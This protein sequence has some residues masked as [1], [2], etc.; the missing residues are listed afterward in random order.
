[1]TFKDAILLVRLGKART[2][3]RK[4]WTD[5]QYYCFDGQRIQASFDVGG[6]FIDDILHDDWEVLT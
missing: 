5:N 1:M 3:K 4:E 6:I 2:I